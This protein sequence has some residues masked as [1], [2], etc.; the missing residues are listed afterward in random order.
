MSML[1]N[2]LTRRSPE[3]AVRVEPQMA[4]SETSG[5]RQ[6]NPDLFGIGFGGQSRVRTL[7]RATGQTATRHAT[8]F[9]C[10]NNIA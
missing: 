7:P 4:A 1:S 10:G 3:R 5:T 8:V 9:A 2:L 6:P